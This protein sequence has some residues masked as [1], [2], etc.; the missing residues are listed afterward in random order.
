M[1]GGS[2]ASKMA[3][4]LEELL[5]SPPIDYSKFGEDQLNRMFEKEAEEI[6]HMVTMLDLLEGKTKMEEDGKMTVGLA[7]CFSR[8]MEMLRKDES[9]FYDCRLLIQADGSF[10]TFC[11]QTYD[12]TCILWYD[13]YQEA[14]QE[15]HLKHY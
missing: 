8:A 4:G 14:V 5:K 13:Q 9:V 3:T 2:P 6:V 1:A 12:E 7:A 11:R 10:L 15:E